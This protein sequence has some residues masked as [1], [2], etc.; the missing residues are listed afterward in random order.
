MKIRELL[1][2]IRN[3]DIVLPEFQREYVWNKDQSKKLL[4]SLI[5]EYPVGALLFWKTDQPPE[6]KNIQERED[7]LGL[8]QVI[9]DGQQR[10]TSLYLLIEGEIPPFY[11]NDDIKNDPRELFFNIDA[12]EFQYYTTNLMKGN[13][14][15]VRV[16]DCFKNDDINVFEIAEQKAASKEEAF[17]LANKY[18][19]YLTNLRNIKN[20]DLPV[21]TV[22]SDAELDD[23]I[24]IFDLVNSQGTKLTDA[25]LALTHIT[26]KWS[27]ARRII[28]QKIDDLENEDFYFDLNFMTRAITGVVAHRALYETVHNEPKVR[29]M[30][31]WDKLRKILDYLVAVL[32][33]RAFINST[34]D[35]STT[36]VLIPIIVYLSVNKGKFPDEKNLK[37]ALHF[38]YN[39]LTWARYSGQ[40]DQ[41]LEYDVITVVR[42]ENPWPTM[43][44]ALIDQRGRIEVK[45]DDLEGRTA[46][47]PLFLSTYIATKANGAVDWFNGLP[48]TKRSARS[49]TMHSHHIFPTSL[50]YK[51]GYDP[52]NHLHRKITNEI[53]N[54]AF[55]TA[56]TNISI[57][58]QLPEKYLPEIEKHY[59]GALAKQFIPMHPEL[60]KMDRYA[61]FLEARRNLIA[62]K[63]N[64]FYKSLITEPIDVKKKPIQELI[65]MGESTTL[66]FKSTLQWDVVRS[67]TNKHLR[68]S[69]LKSIAAFFNSEGG[70]LVIGVEDNGDI[71]GIETDLSLTENSKDKFLN[72]I[73]TL[74]ADHLGAEFAGLVKIRI[75]NGNGQEVCVV[76]V[77][78]SMSPVYFAMDGKKEFFIRMGN[79]TR[80]LDTEETVKYISQNWS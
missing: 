48:L 63:I 60:W 29:L 32:S 31:G 72:L 52:D 33:E 16:V 57:S 19:R 43:I 67:E 11:T 55:L 42:E 10:L 4:T 66:E 25:E 1:D 38:I 24:N 28:K 50:L 73:N 49:Y 37:R 61:D 30:E 3:N 22:P 76:D 77:D 71:L 69:V 58:N 39:A 21:L 65:R 41:R 59:P 78:R 9:L 36:N 44:E 2:G 27:H 80:S 68:K 35:L 64:E 20:T 40:T 5:S 51:N 79:T 13:S 74:I 47:H 34:F 7:R 53:A 56:D 54:R 12:G 14:L 70:T 15:W 75:E 62:I 26:G 8:I 6:L 45:P 17:G 18:T 23:A 46:Q